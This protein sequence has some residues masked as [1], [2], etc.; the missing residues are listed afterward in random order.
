MAS[1]SKNSLS[2]IS[3]GTVV[4]AVSGSACIAVLGFLWVLQSREHQSLQDQ[5]TLSK[6]NCIALT[7]LIRQ[8]QRNLDSLLTRPSLMRQIGKFNLGLSNIVAG[9]VL[10]VTNPYPAIVPSPNPRVPLHSAPIPAL[11]TASAR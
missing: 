10:R 1:P 6:S 5:I 2:D 9:Q 11:A 7:H 8:D 4:Q 3:L